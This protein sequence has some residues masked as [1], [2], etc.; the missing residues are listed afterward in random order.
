M[1][2]NEANDDCDV[3][4]DANDNDVLPVLFLLSSWSLSFVL[5]ITLMLA[6]S[7]RRYRPPSM[8]LSV[9]LALGLSLSLGFSPSLCCRSLWFCLAFAFAFRC[10]VPL[11][12][13]LL[14]SFPSLAPRHPLFLG[15]LFALSLSLF[16]FPPVFSLLL[17]FFSSYSSL[18]LHFPFRFVELSPSLFSLRPG[19]L[20]RALSFLLF[21]SLL[22]LLCISAEATHYVT[23]PI[24]FMISP[25]SGKFKIPQ[26]IQWSLVPMK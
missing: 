26:K 18:T 7:S 21:V 9:L 16:R 8:L 15:C 13:I 25:S 4:V 14:S 1:L 11:S 2:N 6:L 19:S 20:S 23:S 17:F 12:S 22:L 3:D 10:A 5:T 24:P